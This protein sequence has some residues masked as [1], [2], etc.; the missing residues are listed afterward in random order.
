[1]GSTSPRKYKWRHGTREQANL[2]LTIY[3]DQEVIMFNDAL[4]GAH[5]QSHKVHPDN[6]SQMHNPTIIKILCKVVTQYINIIKTLKYH[7]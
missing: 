2:K 4:Y 3:K 1:M 6:L 5:S 7:H